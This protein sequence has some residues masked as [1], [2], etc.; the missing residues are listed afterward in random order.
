MGLISKATARRGMVLAAILTACATHAAEMP[1]PDPEPPAPLAFEDWALFCAYACDIRTRIVG[2]DG[3]D[4]LTLVARAGD[5]GALGIETPLPLFL[6]DPARLTL[7]ST[8]PRAIAWR[9]CG[10]DGCEA[11]APLAPELLADL[12]RELS[13]NVELTLEDGSRVRFG[14]SLLGFTAAWRALSDAP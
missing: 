7:G 9:T 5:G 6:P 8:E 11:R 4:V 12:R 10:A 14:V 3:S 1:R 13:G 2:R